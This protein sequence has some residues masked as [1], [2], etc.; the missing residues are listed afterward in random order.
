MKYMLNVPL[1]VAALL[2]AWFVSLVFMPGPWPGW[3]DGPSRGAMVLV[4]LQ[5]VVLS[6][7]LLLPVIVGVVF[8]GGF[9]WLRIRRGW[10]RLI[11]VLGGSV[12]LAMFAAPCIFIAIGI[13][14]A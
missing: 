9:D 6:W 13:S 3:S 1:A 11:L 7:L 2:Q 8:A 5:P 4:M 10:L 12:L 14:A